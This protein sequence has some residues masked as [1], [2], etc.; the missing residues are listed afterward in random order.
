M[1]ELGSS[2]QCQS[3]TPFQSPVWLDQWYATLGRQHG[4]EPLP[5]A[6]RDRSSGRLLA[7]VP[8]MRRRVDGYDLVEFADLSVT[9][10]N[11]ALIA[12][13]VSLNPTDLRSAIERAAEGADLLNFVKMPRLVGG[14]I[15]PLTQCADV[16]VGDVSASAVRIEGDWLDYTRG[17]LAKKF[18]KEIER[19]WRV[20]VRDGDDARLERVVQ[21]DVGLWVLGQMEQLQEARMR[22]LGQSFHLND[23]PYRAFYRAVLENGLADGSVVMT[24]LRSGT[25]RIVA[26]L[27]G[28]R[29]LDTYAMVRLAQ[30]T[31]NWAHCSPGKLMI[32]RTM[33]ML[34][35]EGVRTFDFTTGDY[36]Y[37]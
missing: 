35:S 33:Q 34:H 28:M 15:N 11:A 17:T 12:S 19:S 36:S 14:E 4:V 13:G 30:D 16:R 22:S 26:S 18:R 31:E 23:M 9:D 8:L 24:V 37:K 32:E 2:Q 1:R 20:F 29:Q 5:V 10:Y 27:I 6:I 25:D 21:A 7:A 3:L